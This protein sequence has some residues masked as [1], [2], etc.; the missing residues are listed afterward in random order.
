MIVLRINPSM[1]DSYFTKLLQSIL[2]SA[3]NDKDDSIIVM[4]KFHN[5]QI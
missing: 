1:Q 3:E 5:I 4:P 2:K